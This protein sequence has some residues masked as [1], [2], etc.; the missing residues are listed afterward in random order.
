MSGTVGMIGGMGPA[1][2]LELMRKII[3]RSPA[4]IEQEHLRILIDNRPQ[5]PDRTAYIMGNGSSP[6]PLLQDSARQL[7]RWGADFVTMACN[8][9]HAF[10]EEVQKSVNIPILN[11]LAILAD[12]IG[13]RT[14]TGSSILLLTTTGA[15]Q[16]GIFNRYLDG[17]KLILPDREIQQNVIMDI[18]YGENGMKLTGNLSGNR[19]RIL[20]IIRQYDEINNL[21]L[22]IA[23]CTE[24]GIL[25]DNI[26]L[27][28]EVINPLD[29]L[30]DE[31]VKQAYGL[32]R[33][34]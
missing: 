27:E 1:S 17:F 28:K 33:N 10:V 14:D 9:A 23:G 6:V 32:D 31:I 25:L 19:E 15:I 12:Y 11:M 22:I 20:E 3:E 24:L 34:Q 13:R 29:C 2:T 5:I 26:S 30:A 8:T 4:R 16:A 18:I 7:E 21:N